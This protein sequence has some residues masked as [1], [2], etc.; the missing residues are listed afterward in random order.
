MNWEEIEKKYPKAFKLI[1]EWSG[2][3]G[4]VMEARWYLRY[5]FNNRRLYDFFDEQGIHG[6]CFSWKNESG[7]V[8][9]YWG[10][11]EYFR[12]KDDEYIQTEA[13]EDYGLREEAEEI[14]WLKEFEILETK[15][16]NE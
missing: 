9:F 15:L 10:I 14:M 4:R 12:Y 1:E 3:Q 6:N 16:N 13:K 11:E 2:N 8:R 5:D 7:D